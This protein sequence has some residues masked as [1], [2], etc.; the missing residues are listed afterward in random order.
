MSAWLLGLCFELRK[1]VAP[2]ASRLP[3]PDGQPLF[4]HAG[5]VLYSWTPLTS[6]WQAPMCSNACGSRL[7][8][9]G[10]AEIYNQKEYSTCYRWR[11]NAPNTRPPQPPRETE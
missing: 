3:P 4:P 7:W 2:G 10:K 5:S 6:H 8:V 1:P 9:D 11:M